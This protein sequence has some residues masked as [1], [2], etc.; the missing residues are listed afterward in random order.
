[1]KTD[2]RNST[3]LAFFCYSQLPAKFGTLLIIVSLNQYDFLDQFNL[4]S[5]L[6]RSKKM[7]RYEKCSHRTVHD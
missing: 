4:L 3:F 5:N 2:T 6:R 1:M 7:L